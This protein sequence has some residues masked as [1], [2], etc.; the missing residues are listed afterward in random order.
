MTIVW[1]RARSACAMS[2]RHKAA[3]G[4]HHADDTLDRLHKKELLSRRKE[5][6]AFLYS[7]RCSLSSSSRDHPGPDP[8]AA[9]P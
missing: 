5:G 4:L 3:L 8:W 1:E 2:A 7:P 9:G 6:R